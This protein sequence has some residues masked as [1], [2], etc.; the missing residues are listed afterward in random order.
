METIHISAE[1]KSALS[2]FVAGSDYSESQV[3]ESAIEGYLAWLK[4]ERKIIQERV[5][6]AKDPANMMSSKEFWAHF[7]IDAD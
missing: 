2:A 6:L 7:D 3:A 1:T 4:R 5:E